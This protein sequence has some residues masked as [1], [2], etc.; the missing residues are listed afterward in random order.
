MMTLGQD[1]D[2]HNGDMA[3]TERRD[4]GRAGFGD[5]AGGD[6][7]IEDESGLGALVGYRLKQVQAALRSR[8]DAVLRPLGLTTPQYACLELLGRSPGASGAELARGAFVSRQTMNVVLRS[9]QDQG[10]VAHSRRMGGG[11]AQPLELTSQGDELWR[12]AAQRV[13]GVEALMVSRLSDEQGRDLHRALTACAEALEG[14]C[15]EH[16]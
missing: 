1:T 12:R 4:A 15:A 3:D 8:I 11:R 7:R 13:A 10:L 5:R 6:R 16:G 14:S 2:M 9:L